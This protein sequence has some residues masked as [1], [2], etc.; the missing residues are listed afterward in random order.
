[1]QKRFS[2]KKYLYRGLL[3]WSILALVLASIPA[4]LAYAI[5]M[6]DDTP[7]GKAQ[8]LLDK[9][10]P[11]QKVG[12]LFLVTFDGRDVGADSKIYD[13]IVNRSVGGV[14]LRADN[15]NF[16]A[17]NTVLQD[18]ADMISAL[19][20]SVYQ[21]SL[22]GTSTNNPSSAEPVNYIPLFI[23]LAQEGDLSPFDQIIQGLTPLP[24]E[25]AIGATWK[26]TLAK[27]VGSVMGQE[28][29]ALG[30]NFYL[31]PSLDVLDILHT[32]IGED[33]G[34]RTFGGDPY[35]VGEMGKAYISGLHTGSNNRLVVIAKH[36]P[37]RGSSD[38]PP[39]EEVATVRKPLEELKQVE[40]APFFAVTGNTTDA[41]SLTD[42]LFLSHIRYQGFQSNIRATTRPV[43]LDQTALETLMSLEPLASWYGNGGVLVSDDLGSQ[44]MRKFFDPTGKSFDARQVARNAFVS[45][46]DLLYVNDF[47]ATNDPDTY[48]TIVHTLEL[49]AQKYR[50]DT[51]FAERVDASVKR[52]L[53]LKFRLYPTFRLETVLPLS[54]ELEAI[55]NNQQVSFDVA[56]QGA[57]LISPPANELA[58]VLPRP[59]ELGDQIVF[60]TDDQSTKPCAT[61]D[62]VEVMGI[63]AL[64][65]AVLRLYGPQA[66]GQTLAGYL[67]SFSFSDLEAY[68]DNKDTVSPE[69]EPSLNRSDWIIFS[70]RNVQSERSTSEVL[71]RFLSELPDYQR[72][73]KIIVFAF[74][75]P[76]YLDATDISKVTAYY[77]LY[78]KTP[79]FIDVAARILFQE[80]PLTG[81]LPV[82]VPGIGYDLISATSPN[83]N[84]VI[85]LYLDIPESTVATPTPAPTPEA[86]PIPSFKIG[87]TIPLR[88]GVILDHNRN[89]VP[90]GTVVKFIFTLGGDTGT[91]QVI[92]T[93]T[94]QGIARAAYRIQTP[95]VLEMRVVSDPAEV[96]QIVRL[97]IEGDKLG[98]ITVIVPT[99]QPTPTLEPTVTLTVAPTVMPTPIEVPPMPRTRFGDWLLSAGFVW[100]GGLG[101]YWLGQKK[102]S[103]RT[104]V[105]IGLSAIL[106]GLGSYL[107]FAF[108]MVFSPELR[109]QITIGGMLLITMGG[110][111]A[112]MGLG[113][114]FNRGMKK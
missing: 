83:P 28:L 16:S 45:G 3:F 1:M 92:E 71:N 89:S 56:R 54:S 2:L 61:C 78:S 35:W 66:G 96:S 30:V 50:E 84:Q 24:N 97:E 23:G 10:T 77:G 7:Q 47:V 48:T 68:L 70:L 99:T 112:G 74:N 73:R 104:G 95:G 40:L 90:D 57:T 75:A 9:M 109:E 27:Q 19:Q 93:T 29:S 6:A 107:L 17:G 44:A 63:E 36:F 41:S 31:G 86:T 39:E 79:A 72:N 101:I 21:A 37:G 85:P 111:V 51:A 26:P 8:A 102:L 22:P 34:T 53:T 106:G 87:E 69:L 20:S 38:R 13:L 12:Q 98:E 42:G 114:W 52:V 5:P 11:E 110:F 59:P 46:N 14:I 88:T 81:A 18:T 62:P 55:G 105:R 60:F 67:S 25:M 49:F 94:E 58:S 82:S 32:D 80:L 76:Y 108:I 15:N 113:W 33:L 103:R 43:S 4:N 64:E 100:G 65:N 91:A